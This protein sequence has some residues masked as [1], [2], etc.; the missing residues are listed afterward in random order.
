MEPRMIHVK[1]ALYFLDRVHLFGIQNERYGSLQYAMEGIINKG[2]GITIRSKKHIFFPSFSVFC[3][4]FI[5]YSTGVQNLKV[6]LF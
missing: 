5:M 3:N 1:E 2:E 6:F 4:M